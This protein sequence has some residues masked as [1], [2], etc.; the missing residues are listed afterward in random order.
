MGI[1]VAPTARMTE[2][3]VAHR[4]LAYLD[5]HAFKPVLQADAE[6]YPPERRAPLERAQ[7][8]VR[9]E[10]ERMRRAGTP[11][12]IYLA[13]HEELAT[14]QAPARHRRLRELDLPTLEDLRVDFEQMANDLGIGTSGAL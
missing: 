11:V 5:E 14:P 10:R 4:L 3:H 6:H 8:E 1:G 2:R 7:A 13:Y 9:L 12:R